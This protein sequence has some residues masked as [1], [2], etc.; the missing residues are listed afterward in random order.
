M[1]KPKVGRVGTRYVHAG[2]FVQ[3]TGQTYTVPNGMLEPFEGDRVLVVELGDQLVT[4]F[5]SQSDTDL[6]PLV[7][8]EVSAKVKVV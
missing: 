6:V 7:P 8:C 3:W 5:E 1:P 2:G 4:A